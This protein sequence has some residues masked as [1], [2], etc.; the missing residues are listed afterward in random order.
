MDVIANNNYLMSMHEPPFNWK[1]NNYNRHVLRIIWE[2][3]LYSHTLSNPDIAEKSKG[4]GIPPTAGGIAVLCP[5]DASE[6]AELAGALLTAESASTGA[7]LPAEADSAG[8]LLAATS[9]FSSE[10]RK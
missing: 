2:K 4:V 7:L 3:R 9:D 5:D 8:A 10:G 1:N 6:E